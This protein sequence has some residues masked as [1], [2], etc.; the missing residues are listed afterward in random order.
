VATKKKKP[1][2]AGTIFVFILFLLVAGGCGTVGYMMYNRSAQ[3]DLE[4]AGLTDVDEETEET[5]ESAKM[6]VNEAFVETTEDE[7]VEM[8][9]EVVSEADADDAYYAY[10]YDD[11]AG[12]VY[13]SINNTIE[14]YYYDNGSYPSAD[15]LA[16]QL[17]YEGI[18]YYPDDE[19]YVAV[20]YD[21]D[22]SSLDD[23]AIVAA[24]DWGRYEFYGNLSHDV[25]YGSV[26]GGEAYHLMTVKG[27]Y[28]GSS[29][30][31]S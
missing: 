23:V 4:V 20:Y 13:D 15:E 17:A 22:S 10:D 11:I 30:T 31:W 21:E 16:A 26:F 25:E 18:G 3:T 6:V 27:E 5:T 1:S 9:T 24:D 12:D 2:K 7:F 29:W 8:A 19:V 28:D 14:E